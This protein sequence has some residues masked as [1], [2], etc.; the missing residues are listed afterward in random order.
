MIEGLLSMLG[1]VPRRHPAIGLDIQATKLETMHDEIVELNAQLDGV[2]ENLIAKA[3]GEY[4]K[5]GEPNDAAI[6]G[7]KL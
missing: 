5:L 3:N 6:K 1:L 7:P 4:H 2:K